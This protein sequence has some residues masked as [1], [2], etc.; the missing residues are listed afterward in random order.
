MRILFVSHYATPHIGGIETVIHWLRRELRNRGH[1]VVHVAS[2]AT[3]FDLEQLPP[4][5]GVIRVPAINVLENKLGVPYPIFSPRLMTVLARELKQADVVHAHGLLY[6]SSVLALRYAKLRHRGEDGPVRVLTEHVGHVP[7]E[8]ALLDKMESAAIATVGR[9]SVKAAESVV[10]LN[11]QVGAEVEALGPNGPVVQIPNG[12]DTDLFRPAQNGERDALRRKFGWDDDLPR[13]LFVGRLVAKKGLDTALE[14]AAASLGKFELVVAGPGPLQPESASGVKVLGPIPSERV[15]ELYR[16]ADAL[17]L[18]SR[19]EGF[20]VTVQEAMA[21]GLPVVMTND[22]SYARY[23]D[24]A[25]DG[26]TLV[27]PAPVEIARTLDSLLADGEALAAAGRAGHQHARGAFTWEQAAQRHERLYEGLLAA[28]QL[29]GE[30]L[31]LAPAESR[32]EVGAQATTAS[33]RGAIS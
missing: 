20:P 27:P 5:E 9:L 1:E 4:D 14:A 18:P 11:R 28:R 23:L 12:I 17:L 6:Q 3:P 29:P 31:E 16:A 26:V 24:G 7:Y 21:S 32:V 15:A 8:S 2:S 33:E 30:S 25:G 22:P 10:V 13:V 19:G